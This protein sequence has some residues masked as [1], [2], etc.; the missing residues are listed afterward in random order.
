[1]PDRYHVVMVLQAGKAGVQ[2]HRLTEL[3]PH[4]AHGCPRLRSHTLAGGPPRA[5]HKAW[6]AGHP[7][8][9]SRL[10][11]HPADSDPEER[12][13][14]GDFLGRILREST[15]GRGRSQERPGLSCEAG[16]MQGMKGDRDRDTERQRERGVA[17]ETERDRDRDKQDRDRG[18]GK[19]ETDRDTEMG[20][21]TVTRS[22]RKGCQL[23]KQRPAWSPGRRL[24]RAPH[25]PPLKHTRPR[26]CTA[27]ATPSRR[28]GG[29]VHGGSRAR[30]PLGGL[31]PCLHSVCLGGP[32]APCGGQSRG[33]AARI[34][35]APHKPRTWRP[36][37]RT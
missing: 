6:S 31:I 8:P 34:C 33:T 9:A 21:G 4:G 16:A 24:P 35:W 29:Y 36:A 30:P 32:P 14:E 2:M 23:W 11:I 18:G 28:K 3:C 17:T 25:H 12:E 20:G 27:E 13:Q 5:S 1:M 10:V 15:L 22:R 26:R 7:P 19:T 37:Q